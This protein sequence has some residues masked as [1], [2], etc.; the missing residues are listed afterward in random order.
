MSAPVRFDT[1]Q[2]EA[3]LAR[4]YVLSRAVLREKTLHVHSGPCTSW[5]LNQP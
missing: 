5:W 2:V 4:G 1:R 3:A